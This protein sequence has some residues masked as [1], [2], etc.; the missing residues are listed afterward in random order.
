[1]VVIG[2]VTACAPAPSAPGASPSPAE[3]VPSVNAARGLPPGCETIDLRSPTGER[4]DLT[5]EWTGSSTLFNEATE[6]TLMNELGGCVY[7]SVTGVD[8]DGSETISN[9]SG[10][11]SSDFT[12]EFDI[13]I[14]YQQTT[15]LLF[16]EYSSMV[17]LIEWDDQGRIRLRED[18]E[19]GELAGRCT[20]SRFQCP[21]PVI[22]YRVDDAPRQ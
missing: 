2:L 6:V 4:V 16:G 7:G 20:D 22:W 8:P 1:M 5:G 10:H 17:M 15:F 3:P 13:V 19:P 11:L 21:L 9:L 12:I 18:R 14:V